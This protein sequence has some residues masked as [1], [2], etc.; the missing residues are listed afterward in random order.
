MTL[1]RKLPF[2]PKWCRKCFSNKLAGR[3]NPHFSSCCLWAYLSHCRQPV[4]WICAC[5]HADTYMCMSGVTQVSH[6]TLV[7]CQLR[8]VAPHKFN[9]GSLQSHLYLN[10]GS[11]LV[12]PQPVSVCPPRSA[13]VY[14]ALIC[15][16]HSLRTTLP[17]ITAAARQCQ[18]ELRFR[19]SH[20][21]SC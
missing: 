7:L 2:L 17:S 14:G 10:E 19:P 20:G 6:P 4:H 15:L 3:S 18:W 9:F 11:G 1:E 5:H 21:S 8:G 12:E 16:M 13:G